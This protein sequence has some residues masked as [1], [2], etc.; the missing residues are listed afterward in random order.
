MSTQI[1]ITTPGLTVRPAASFLGI[2]RGEFLKI[3]R[4]FW[5]MLGIL[6][7]AFL[8]GFLLGSDAPT[9]KADLQNTPLHFLYNSMEENLVVFRI[10]SGIVLLVLTSFVVG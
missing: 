7:V 3:K 8:V 9:I 10:F 1:V 4:L 2:M 6:T 5:L